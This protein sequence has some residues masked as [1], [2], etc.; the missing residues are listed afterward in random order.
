MNETIH[1][2]IIGFGSIGSGFVASL[3]QNTNLIEE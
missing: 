3:N 1:I 2:G